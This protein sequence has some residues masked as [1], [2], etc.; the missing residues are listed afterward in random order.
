M[1]EKG[2]VQVDARDGKEFRAHLWASCCHDGRGIFCG[3]PAHLFGVSR[4]GGGGTAAA[5]AGH[6]QSEVEGGPF[7]FLSGLLD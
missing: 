4:L 5:V 6:I 1:V 2:L 7:L 3:N